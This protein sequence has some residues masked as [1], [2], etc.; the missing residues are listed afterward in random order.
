VILILSFLLTGC[1]Q[2]SENGIEVILSKEYP[3]IRA[4][5][6]VDTISFIHLE[7]TK[8]SLLPAFNKCILK[9]S[10]NH[11][12]VYNKVN[13]SLIVFNRQ[14]KYLCSFNHYGRG[15]QEYSFVTQL[16]LNSREEIILVDQGRN[17]LTFDIN[18]KL[19]YHKELDSKCL[20]MVKMSTEGYYAVQFVFPETNAVRLV[21][22]DNNFIVKKSIDL[23]NILK[24]PRYYSFA[25]LGFFKHRLV[26]TPYPKDSLYLLNKDNQVIPFRGIDL[27]KNAASSDVDFIQDVAALNNKAFLM[28]SSII[29]DYLFV[30]GGEKGIQTKVINLIDNKVFD[31]LRSRVTQA[32]IVPSKNGSMVLRINGGV[33]GHK[34]CGILTVDEMI[35]LKEDSRYN[36]IDEITILEDKTPLDANDN[37]VIQ[38]SY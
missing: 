5:T 32:Y 30:T 24:D 23:S 17:I 2:T 38:I 33:V 12:V 15:P 37:F 22:L 9:I 4:E 34:Y 36:M 3:I 13:K 8:K 7:T 16:F 27:G 14:G 19:L 10:S 18:G 35:K 11:I 29:G 25:S 20:R 1:N 28:N 21:L 31:I 6:L 26:I